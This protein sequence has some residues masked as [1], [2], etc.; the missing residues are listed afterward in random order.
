MYLILFKI[1]ITQFRQIKFSINRSKMNFLIK[2]LN[3]LTKALNLLLLNVISQNGRELLMNK[4]NHQHKP[5]KMRNLKI[6]NKQIWIRLNHNLK[7]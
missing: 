5:K 2:V 1:K 7:N 6:T 4:N 3:I